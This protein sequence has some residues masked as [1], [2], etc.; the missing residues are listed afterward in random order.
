[1]DVIAPNTNPSLQQRMVMYATRRAIMARSAFT[2]AF[3]VGVF[4]GLTKQKP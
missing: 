4:N 3:W 1:M 2:R